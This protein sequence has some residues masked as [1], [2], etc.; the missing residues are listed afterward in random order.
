MFFFLMFKLS[1]LREI[2]DPDNPDELR[3]LDNDEFDELEEK[4]KNDIKK[5]DV[6]LNEL[7][8]ADRKVNSLEKKCLEE[9]IRKLKENNQRLED[10]LQ[11]NT[12]AQNPNKQRKQ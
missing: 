8:E 3:W 7:I 10:E 1:F 12:N 9:V 11:K 5:L 6:K 2:L 4:L